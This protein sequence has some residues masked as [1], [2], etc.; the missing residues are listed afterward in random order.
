MTLFLHIS[1]IHFR[2]SSGD[3]TDI[4]EDLRNELVLDAKAFVGE[5]GKP[6]GILISGDIGFSGQQREYE[7]AEAWVDQLCEAVGR[8]GLYVWCV[9]GNHDVDQGT[10]KRSGL[11][12]QLHESLRKAGENEIDAVLADLLGDSAAGEP[13]YSTI[14]GYNTWFGRKFG[15]EIT[16]Q[17]PCWSET[18]TLNDSSKL[19]INGVNSTIVSDH[20]DNIHKKIILGRYQLPNRNDGVTD[21][22][23]CHHPPDWWQD[24]EQLSDDMGNRCHVQL[25]GHKH[26]H[27]LKRIDNSVVLSAGAVHPDRREDGW[28]PRYNWLSVSV[29]GEGDSR[30]LVVNVFPRVW[31]S[32]ATKFIA[33]SNSCGG[34]QCVEH[35]LDLEPWSAQKP[36]AAETEGDR[37]SEKSEPLDEEGNA[38]KKS[39]ILTYRFFELPHVRRLDVVRDLDLIRDEDEGLSDTELFHSIMLRA[40][41]EGVLADLWDK[42]QEQHGDGEYKA[43]PYRTQEEST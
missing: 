34:Q 28:E 3:V 15:C 1:D 33:D 4:D 16:F 27:R 2:K 21:L 26:H 14:E 22:L 9:P 29:V 8:D 38:M 17:Q 18:F 5:H 31:S 36:I 7:I 37:G 25:F 43:N 39:R 30:K 35:T 23:L 32:Q 12:K 40:R 42:V 19:R 10:V 24:S 6:D 20:Q 13:L 41:D 11:L